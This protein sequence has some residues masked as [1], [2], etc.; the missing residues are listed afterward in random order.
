MT[1]KKYILTG[2]A[3]VLLLAGCEKEEKLTPSNMEVDW[4]QYL[5]MSNPVVKQFY[6]ECGVGLLT[7][8][9]DSRNLLHQITTYWDQAFL[10]KLEIQDI[11]NA[12][13]FLQKSLLS[14]FTNKQFIKDNFPRTILLAGDV[15]LGRVHNQNHYYNPIIE[16]SNAAVGVPAANSIHS[17]FNAVA[18][19]FACKMET[20]NYS[21]ANYNNYARDN[22]YIFLSCL[23]ERNN[24]YD[25]LGADFHL[26][27]MKYYY[28]KCLSC[29]ASV[30]NNNTPGI[31]QEEGNQTSVINTSKYWY[32]NKG[33][34]STNRLVPVQTGASL[35]D[36]IY[37]RSAAGITY[38]F[39]EKNR[40]T[41]TILNQMIF[42]TEEVY[43]SYP[44]II[45]GRF[46]AIMAKF[47]EWGIDIRRFN[48]TMEYAFP[49]K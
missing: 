3:A 16:E 1:M 7:N 2:L 40:E 35:L 30:N 46:A 25:E 41:R 24:L 10:E 38:W 49:R 48:P 15:L 12:F 22:M 44:D 45:K 14:Y 9:D 5:D 39:P 43:D 42:V 26:P 4:H 32:W 13:E 6:D 27:E 36:Q 8:F 37:L 34:V 20:I 21:E 18:F 23:F 17:I 19:A 28:G 11:E 33:F 29:D 47:D 31:W